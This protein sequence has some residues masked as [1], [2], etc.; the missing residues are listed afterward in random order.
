MLL[1]IILI[2]FDNKK[3]TLPGHIIGCDPNKKPN[4][5]IRVPKE[6]ILKQEQHLS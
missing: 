2:N 3:T 5:L 4:N 1:K 6:R